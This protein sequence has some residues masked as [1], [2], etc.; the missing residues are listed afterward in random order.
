MVLPNDQT[1]AYVMKVVNALANAIACLPRDWAQDLLYILEREYLPS[2]SG[3][4]NGCKVI[5]EESNPNRIVIQ[6]DFHHM[7]DGMYDGWTCHKAII[8]PSL[9]FGYDIRI[10]GR[11]RRGIK[12]YLAE[13]ISNALEQDFDSVDWAKHAKMKK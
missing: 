13:V 8:T 12:D 4:D 1:E 2:G 7:V 6:V 9:Q 11:D 10:T 3:I 5:V